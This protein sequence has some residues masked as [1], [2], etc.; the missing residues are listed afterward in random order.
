MLAFSSLFIFH[1]LHLP[2][3]VYLSV[4]ASV[5]C[6]NFLA[7]VNNGAKNMDMQIF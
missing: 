5:V 6:L 1:C 4:D 7:I 2:R 3:F